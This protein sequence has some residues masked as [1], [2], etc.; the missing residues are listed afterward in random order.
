ME[1]AMFPV[2]NGNPIRLD[3]GIE[4]VYSNKLIIIDATSAFL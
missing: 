1:S 3:N 2:I 4:T